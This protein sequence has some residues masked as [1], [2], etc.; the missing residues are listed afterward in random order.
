MIVSYEETTRTGST[1]PN[2]KENSNMN[3]SPLT[4]LKVAHNHRT[5]F[6]CSFIT[7]KISSWWLL[8]QAHTII[9]ST[10]FKSTCLTAP[11]HQKF[12]KHI[13]GL[14]F[15]IKVFWFTA[16]AII[17]AEPH[18]PVLFKTGPC[19]NHSVQHIYIL[20]YFCH[21]LLIVWYGKHMHVHRFYAYTGSTSGA[22][23][24]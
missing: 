8:I 17:S 10:T 24:S 23:Y 9:S 7:K 18:D 14:N 19:A 20:T 11:V 2:K 1:T 12:H 6:T 22:S 3:S 13:N 4:E 15:H 16:L 5:L 21:S